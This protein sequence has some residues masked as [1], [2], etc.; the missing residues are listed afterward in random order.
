MNKIQRKSYTSLNKIY[1]LT[2]TIHK[3]LTLLESKE[4]KEL[5]ISYLKKLSEEDKIVVYGFVIMPNHIH[6]IW[7]QINNNGKET[8]QG[9]FLKYTAH[10]FLKVLKLKGENHKYAVVA[11]NK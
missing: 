6:I 4:N 9:S 5:I 2:A 7:E 8:A 3:W 11:S 10:E 1:F